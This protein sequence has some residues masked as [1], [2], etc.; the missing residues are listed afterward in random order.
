MSIYKNTDLE[1]S[2]QQG[3]EKGGVNTNFYTEDK[4]SASIRIRLSSNG[5]YLDLTKI[6]LKPV[7]FLFHKDGSIF[8]I[9]EFKD[10]I[11]DKG[12]IQYNVSDDVIKHAGKFEA[13]MLLKNNSQSFH[14]ANFNFEIKD[15]G[16]EGIVAKEINVEIIEDTLRKIIEDEAIELLD[17]DFKSEVF[18]N[19]KTYVTENPEEFKGVQGLQGPQGVKGDKG[20]KG[21]KGEQGIQGLQGP[22]G[23]QGIQGIQGERGFEG[24]Q[25]PQGEPG[26]TPNTTGWQKYKL[27]ENDGTLSL[28]NM[29]KDLVAF[30]ALSPGNYYMSNVPISSMGQTSTT[31]FVTVAWRDDATVKHITF[32]P[33]NS[34]QVFMMRYYNSWSEWTRIDGID[35]IIVSSTQP[36]TAVVWFEVLD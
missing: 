22:Q 24:P 2:L 16:V 28:T 29:G 3:T 18:D 23:E 4:G 20:D 21:D 31:G 12:L 25:G 17:D 11:P 8:E 13:K 35:N 14:V 15:S 19:F 36:S 30:Q 34:G 7:L 5:N 6:D 33:Y 9:R 10:I 32:R 1:F 27:T 26:V